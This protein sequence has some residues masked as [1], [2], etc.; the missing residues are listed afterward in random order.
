ML[1]EQVLR[2]IQIGLLC[3]QDDPNERPSMASVVLML[4][5]NY[6][7]LCSPSAPASFSKGGITGETNLRQRSMA[8]NLQENMQSDRH[9]T[10]S[11]ASSVNDVSIS[12]LEPR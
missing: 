4:K 10:V 5:S 7:P 8:P 2:C 11:G 6:I 3:V 1:D 12:I 9:T